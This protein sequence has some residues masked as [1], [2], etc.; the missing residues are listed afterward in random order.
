MGW[1]GCL[2]DTRALPRLVGCIYSIRT[3]GA[4]SR[5]TPLAGGNDSRRSCVLRPEL[6]TAFLLRTE[7]RS[8][9][10]IYHTVNI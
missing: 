1:L 2:M 3:A 7:S 4:T 5:E 9:I 6:R 10:Y 8:Q